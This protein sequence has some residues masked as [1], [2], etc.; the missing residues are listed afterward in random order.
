MVTPDG[1]RNVFGFQPWHW[2]GKDKK[3]VGLMHLD[4]N[5]LWLLQAWSHGVL[6]HI[7]YIAL[8]VG[9]CYPL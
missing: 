8:C 5:G 7:S 9:L 6:F 2:C 4:W 1:D 3:I